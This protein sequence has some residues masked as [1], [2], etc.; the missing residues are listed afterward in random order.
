MIWMI[1]VFILTTVV[2]NLVSGN[3][4]FVGKIVIGLILL[5]VGIKLWVP[6]A[7][8]VVLGVIFGT[9]VGAIKQ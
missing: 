6:A 5:F 4:G 1:L 8:A 9:A 7:V 3:L 2:T